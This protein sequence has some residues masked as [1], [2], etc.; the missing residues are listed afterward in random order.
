MIPR[1]PTL[2]P[3]VTAGLV[4]GVVALA[5]GVVLTDQ[6]DAADRP[7]TLTVVRAHLEVPARLGSPVDLEPTA[8]A[9][10]SAPPVTATPVREDPPPSTA[11]HAGPT[12]ADPMTDVG[13]EAAE[14][15]DDSSQAARARAARLLADLAA[16]TD[17]LAA[18]VLGEELAPVARELDPTGRRTL[19]ALARDGDAPRAA[20]LTALGRLEPTG[21]TVDLVRYA[22]LRRPSPEAR[23]AGVDALALLGERG[24]PGEQVETAMLEL[25][26]PSF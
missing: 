17:P 20:A 13:M 18:L 15:L 24:A 4:A 26:D 6:D 12:H 1:R 8:P 23:A 22:V 3:L 2:R 10:S 7:T 14:V 21:E 9:M 25:A 11:Q 19:L 16:E 5:L